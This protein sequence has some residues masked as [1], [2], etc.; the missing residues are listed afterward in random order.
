M[1]ACRFVS[2]FIIKELFNLKYFF[3]GKHQVLLTNMHIA[4]HSIR[5]CRNNVKIF[6][7]KASK[8]TKD[9]E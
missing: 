5:Y 7:Y 2:V 4:H 6:T 9:L 8:L 1:Y 3:I